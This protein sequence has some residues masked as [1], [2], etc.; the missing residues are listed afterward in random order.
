MH[1]FSMSVCFAFVSQRVSRCQA[2]YV[3]Y[4]RVLR[5][6]FAARKSLSN[7]KF[8]CSGLGCVAKTVLQLRKWCGSGPSSR[9]FSLATRDE[10]WLPPMIVEIQLALVN[11]LFVLRFEMECLN[12]NIVST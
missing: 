1:V 4:V 10:L 12:W 6:S 2:P 11:F 7:A 3:F 8:V 9:S 5:F